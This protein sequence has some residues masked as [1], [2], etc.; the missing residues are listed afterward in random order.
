[1]T[2]G[3]AAW[4][5]LRAE[6][7]K[8]NPAGA[9]VLDPFSGRGMIPLEAARLGLE[10]HAIEYAPVAVVASHLLTDYPFRDWTSEPNCPSREPRPRHGTLDFRW[11]GNP[12]RP[13]LPRRRD[14]P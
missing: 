13:L 2:G 9:S 6:I 12:R 7:L 5:D 10:S 1:M 11:T 4:D 14:L 8:A 3:Y